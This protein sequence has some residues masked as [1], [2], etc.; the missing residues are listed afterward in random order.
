[1]KGSDFIIE[2]SAEAV[3]LVMIS[4][5]I[6]IIIIIIIIIIISIFQTAPYFL[7]LGRHIWFFYIYIRLFCFDGKLYWWM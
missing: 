3:T 5:S 2:K 1:M 6:C 7:W 4:Y